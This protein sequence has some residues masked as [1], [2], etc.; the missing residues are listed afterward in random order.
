M[1]DDPLTPT[2]PLRLWALLDAHLICAATCQAIAQGWRIDGVYVTVSQAP[3]EQAR[4]PETRCWCCGTD[5]PDA[6]LVRLGQHPEV[7]VCVQCT[8]LLRQRAVQ[9]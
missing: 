9:R 8:H 5:Y 1:T 7:G 3:S 6:E 2:P 4:A